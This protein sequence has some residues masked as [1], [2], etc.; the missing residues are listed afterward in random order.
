MSSALQQ[1]R[2]LRGKTGAA[3]VVGLGAAALW[4]TALAIVGAIA[5]SNNRDGGGKVAAGKARPGTSAGTAGGA[6]VG[7]PGD[8]TPAEGAAA[9]AAGAPGA[10]A[11]PDSSID[12]GGGP[13]VSPSG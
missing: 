1:I 8:T 10:Q 6:A 13:V 3:A 11:S 7:A 2:E 4:I 12:G 9:G 5:V